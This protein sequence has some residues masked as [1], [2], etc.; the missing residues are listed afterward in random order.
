MS[1]FSIQK[2]MQLNYLKHKQLH[3]HIH[4]PT[5]TYVYQIKP[6]P[7][8]TKHETVQPS[9]RGDCHSILVDLG[10]DQFLISIIDKGEENRI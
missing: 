9:Q 6:V 8:L 3:P 5:L 7:Y 4:F 2:K 10:N 1:R